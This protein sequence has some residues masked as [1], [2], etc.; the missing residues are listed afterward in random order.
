VG[1]GIDTDGG[2]GVIRNLQE[3]RVK[4]TDESQCGRKSLQICRNYKRGALYPPPPSY[5]RQ[6]FFAGKPVVDTCCTSVVQRLP[7]LRAR[8]APWT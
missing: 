4:S 8:F 1:G 2:H 3:I 5:G 7:S 6:A